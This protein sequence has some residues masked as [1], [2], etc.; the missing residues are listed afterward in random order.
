MAEFFVLPQSSPTM[1]IGVLVRWRAEE[2]AALAP[3]DVLAEVETDKATMEIEV[4]DPCVLLKRLASDG[5][6]IP[7]GHPIAITGEAGEKISDLLAEFA[8]LS[9]AKTAPA[10]SESAASESAASES[11]A[12]APAERSSGGLTRFTWKGRV[13]DPA[14]MEMPAAFVPSGFQPSGLQPAGAPTPRGPVRAAP[15][16]RRAAHALG[17]DLHAVTGTG[18]HGRVLRSDVEAFRAPAQPTSAPAGTEVRNSQM[19]KAIARRL[20]EV[21][22][23]AP[24]FTLTANLACDAL[25]AFRSQLKGDGQ[26]QEAGVK[27]SYNDVLLKACARA[28]RDVPE[29]NASWGESAITRHSGVHIGVAVALPDGLITPVVRDADRKGLAAVAQ[30]VRELAG[31][32]RQMKLRKDEYTGSTFTISNLGMMGIESFNAILN[33]PEVVILAVGALQR[34]PVVTASGE[35]G[36]GW[37]MRV[38]LTCDHRVVDG[39]LGARFLQAVR[40]YVEAPALLAS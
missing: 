24:V 36:V 29:V 39:A 28:L 30:E 22:A 4:F 13:I 1:E 15:A 33:P 18:P 40:R 17:I 9:A 38:T 14:I 26:L 35:L 6:E 12:I 3:Q 7:V 23:D 32:A 19:R 27:V 20:K 2:G 5:D 25:V 34:E 10:P 37:R 8:A 16:A 31:R 21:W 11:A